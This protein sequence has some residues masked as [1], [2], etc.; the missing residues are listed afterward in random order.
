MYHVNGIACRIL[1]VLLDLYT[2]LKD[3][4]PLLA[5][6]KAGRNWNLALRFGLELRALSVRFASLIFR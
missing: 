2:A 5:G 1:V 3:A 4:L 6:L